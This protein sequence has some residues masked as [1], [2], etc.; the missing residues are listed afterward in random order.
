MCARPPSLT[1][2]RTTFLV[3][4]R[5]AST[6]YADRIIVLNQGRIIEQGQYEELTTTPGSVFAELLALQE[7]PQHTAPATQPVTA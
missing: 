5:L 1:A 2:G 7:S 3:T 4:H 6:R